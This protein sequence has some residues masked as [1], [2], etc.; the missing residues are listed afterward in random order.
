MSFPSRHTMRCIGIL[1]IWAMLLPVTHAQNLVPNHS[2]ET[3]LNCP[4][5]I[6]DFPFTASQWVSAVGTADYFNACMSPGYL[7]VPDNS[8]G[9]QAAHS[10]DAYVGL[11]GFVPTFYTR[12]C[13]QVQLTSPMV[14]DQCYTVGFY[15]S[16]ADAHCG[17]NHFGAFLS[18]NA[19]TSAM[20]IT[21][22][23]EWQGTFLSD[24]MNWVHVLGFFVATGGEQ[25]ITIG[26]FYEDLETQ[27]DPNCLGLQHAY[28]YV[29]DVE[30]VATPVEPFDLDLGGPVTACDSFVIDPGVGNGVFLWS[31]GSIEPTLTVYTSGTYSVTVSYGCETHED[32][33]DVTIL[34]IPVVDLPDILP[35]LCAGDT[36]TFSVDPGIGFYTWQDGSHDTDY[37]ITGS[38]MYAVTLDNGCNL[39]SDFVDV[40]FLSPPDPFSFGPDFNLCQGDEVPLVFDPSAGDFLWQDQSTGSEYT[41]TTAGTYALTISNSC[42]EVSDE[43]EVG[44]LDPP[45]AQLGTDTD[46]ICTGEEILLEFSPDEGNFIWQDG[47]TNSHFSIFD[48]GLY[49]VT[50][51]NACGTDEDAVYV[52]VLDPPFVDLGFEGFA[53]QGDTLHLDIGNPGWSY[54]WQDDSTLPMLDVTISGQYSVTV[55]NQCGEVSDLFNATFTPQISPF[56][57][58]PDV[59]LCPG[60]QVVLYVDAPGA[61]IEWNNMSTSDTLLVQAAGTY[62]VTAQNSCSLYSDTVVVAMNGNAPVV[63]LPNDFTLC[64]GQSAILDPMIS[65]V[66]YL[67]NDGTMLP[68]L[69]VAAPGTYAITVSNSC[70]T[71][72]DT[73]LITGGDPAPWVDLGTDTTICAGDTF[74]LV[75]ASQYVITWLWQ[76]GTITNAYE[77]S[78]PGMIMVQASNSCGVAYD[79]INVSLLP[80]I[81]PL[82]LGP[83]IA[84]CPDDSVTLSI[85]VPGVS[86]TWSDGTTQPQLTIHDSTTVYAVIANQCGMSAD[87]VDILPLPDISIPDLGS[88]QTLCP[89]DAVILSTGIIDVN[90]L[91]QDGSTQSTFIADHEGTFHVSISNSC[92]TASDTIILTES[93]MGPVLDL[94]PDTSTCFGQPL[95]LHAG[96]GGVQY[97]W[98]DGSTSSELVVTSAGMYALTVTNTCGTDADTITV[99]INNGPPPIHLGPDLQL[100][101][102]QAATLGTGLSDVQYLWQDGSDASELSV[103]TAGIYSLMVSNECGTSV[104][105][106]TVLVITIPPVIPLGKDT[107][108]CDGDTLLL[109]PMVDPGVLIEW[110]DQ[111]TAP[112]YLVTQPGVLVLTAFNFCG[113]SSDSMLVTYQHP[114]LTFSLGPDTMICQ[115]AAITLQAPVMSADLLWQDGSSDMQLLVQDEGQYTLQLSNECGMSEDDINVTFNTDHPIVSLDPEVMWCPGDQLTLEAAQS[116]DAEYMWSTGETTSSIQVTTPGVYSVEVSAACEE[117]D[118][119]TIVIPMDDCGETPVFYIPNVFSPNGDGINDAFVLSTNRPDLITSLEATIYDRWGNKVYHSTDVSFTWDGSFHE[120]QMLPG[121]YLYV[122]IVNYVSASGEK[123]KVLKGDVTLVR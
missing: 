22:Q 107:N 54:V 123:S 8:H 98:Q 45:N 1:W 108:L 27:L 46:T 10:G 93:T 109:S 23:V 76:D 110:Q 63:Q 4:Y 99:L 14:A 43:I 56:S 5:V 59:N 85:A 97:M 122:V 77:I 30:V 75:P 24:T 106:V 18:T 37:T 114:P 20:G 11:Y 12:E 94:G 13:I 102:G 26:N 113:A 119:Q 35:L 74:G 116:F 34:N 38:G 39:S 65:G 90:Y 61:M 44:I 17:I 41:I 33:I 111:S 87:T 117:V 62:M 92:G 104:D 84:L 2:F 105:S 6:N 28:Y 60:D 81:P 66:T 78:G 16:L 79:T 29:D 70:G 95:S 120:D 71:S 47:S 42:G 100:C 82:D 101:D 50:I 40:V 72:T 112:T 80:A 19:P 53:C 68:Q 51:T 58:G 25:Y 118:G 73:V 21:P 32:E 89:G 69:N 86:I 103:T 49:A 48:T 88:D 115:G 57:L 31:D 96:I 64:A 121:V 91:W 83:D 67:W 15:V 36:Y 52:D 9:W 7:S 55:S 3:Y